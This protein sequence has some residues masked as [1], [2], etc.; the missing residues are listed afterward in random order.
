MMQDINNKEGKGNKSE[1]VIVHEEKVMEEIITE[2]LMVMIIAIIL[3]YM[4]EDQI[5]EVEIFQETTIVQM[6]DI[7][8][9]PIMVEDIWDKEH[10]RDKEVK[11]DM[12]VKGDKE[13]KEV[14]QDRLDKEDKEDKGSVLL[15]VIEMEAITIIVVTLTMTD[16]NKATTNVDRD[17]VTARIKNIQTC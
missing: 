9:K 4:K 16:L 15:P 14:K 8:L 17:S 7:T 1:V 13:F 11:E 2:A 3:E 10:K 12:R 6:L 5:T